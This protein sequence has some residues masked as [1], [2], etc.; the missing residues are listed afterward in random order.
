VPTALEPIDTVADLI[1]RLGDIPPHRI[2]WNPTPGTATEADAIRLNDSVSR[3]LVEL[4]DGTLVE[5]AMGFPE[6][7]LASWIVTCL[8]NFVTPHKLGIVGGA[9]LLI[10]VV[11]TQVRLPDVSYYPWSSI[12]N[13]AEL[14]EPVG[15]IAP[16][17]AVEVISPSN[18]KREIERKR[19]E[20]FS[21]GTVLFWV[22]DPKNETVQVYSDAM[23]F[24]V[25]TTADT[26]DGGAVLPGFTLAVSELFGYLDFPTTSPS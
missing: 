3:R 26:L 17:I 22:V 24:Q 10:R 9:D 14:R 21:S 20:F 1:H 18:T 19:I 6:S 23:T 7:F 4:I 2:L 15:R 5:K 8:N 16:A 25:L 13:A 12:P 11:G